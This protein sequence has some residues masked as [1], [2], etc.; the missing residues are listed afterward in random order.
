M[1]GQFYDNEI[2]NTTETDPQAADAYIRELSDTNAL[3]QSLRWMIT[4]SS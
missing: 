1:S 3:R 2:T 4:P